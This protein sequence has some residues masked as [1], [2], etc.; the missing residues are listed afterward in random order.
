MGTEDGHHMVH[1]DPVARLVDLELKLDPDLVTTQL[2]N[3]EENHAADHQLTQRAAKSR[4]AQLTEDGHH[5]VH[6]DPAA[7]LVEPVPRPDPEPVLTQNHSMEEKHAVDHQQTHK[8]AKSRIVQLTEDGHHMVH[9]DPVAK[10]VDLELKLDPDPVPT[11]DHSMA[12]N[13]AVDHQPAPEAART[14]NAQST[15]DGHHMVV[16]DPAP[17]HAVEVPRP[18]TDHATTPPLSTEVHHAVVHHLH[19]EAATPTDVL[20]SLT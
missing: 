19:L 9:M 14:K 1:M 8:A 16:T 13:H 4:N 17:A 12:E 20:R 18:D 2:Q 15:E 11:Q 7:R 10:H 5:M 3:T 6:S